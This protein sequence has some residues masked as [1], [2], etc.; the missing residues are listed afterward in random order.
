M[1]AWTGH[2]YVPG[3]PVVAGDPAGSR[4]MKS[5]PLGAYF[6]VGRELVMWYQINAIKT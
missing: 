5:L 3:A 2:L 1:P 6:A 4:Q